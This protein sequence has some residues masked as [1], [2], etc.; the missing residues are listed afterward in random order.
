MHF[1]SNFSTENGH[2]ASDQASEEATK[3]DK[4]FGSEKGFVR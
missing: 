2:V 1:H 4:S 3:N